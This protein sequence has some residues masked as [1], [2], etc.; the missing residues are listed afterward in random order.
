MV[1][2]Q[3]KVQSIDRA[4]EILEL[5][6][7]SKNG[8]SIADISKKTK[9]HK[10]TV[11]RL[12]VSMAHRNYVKQDSRTS[13][14]YAGTRISEMG[15]LVMEHIDIVH[16]AKPAMEKLCDVVE[17]TVHLVMREGNEIVY[18]Q[19]VENEKNAMRMFSR[20]GMRRPMYCTA[21]GKV[22]LSVCGEDER[23]KIWKESEIIPF[24]RNTI[25]KYDDLQKALKKIREE[26]YSKDDEENEIGVRCIAVA[27]P[28]GFEEKYALSV[29][30][31]VTRMT[32][33]RIKQWVPLLIQTANSISLAL[34]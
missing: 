16:L 6:C 4:F 18:I 24:T 34:K 3:Q 20:L 19:K 9:L 12:L 29:S 15:N 8:L 30:A 21:V 32:D 31:P 10:S 11:H 23:K 5:L 13:V 17:E 2:E 26:G 33:E 14:Y 25:L 7:Q 27:I 22:L 28:N 1:K